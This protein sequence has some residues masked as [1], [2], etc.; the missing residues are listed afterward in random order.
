M[1]KW[2]T[3]RR[4]VT[5]AALPAERQDYWQAF[6]QTLPKRIVSAF[7]RGI[8]LFEMKPNREARGWARTLA[9]EFTPPGRDWRVVEREALASGRARQH[10][11][12][13]HRRATT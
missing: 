8:V 6:L 3:T 10:G 5:W 4:R 7:R 1:T 13:R 2:K 9:R 12:R 11:P